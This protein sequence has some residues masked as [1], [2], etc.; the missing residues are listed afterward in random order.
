MAAKILLVLKQEGRKDARL[1]KLVRTFKKKGFQLENV[2]LKNLKFDQLE[3][4]LEKVKSNHK[5]VERI[6]LISNHRLLLW[7]WF[8]AYNSLIDDFIYVPAIEEKD[9]FHQ[10]PLKTLA[11]LYEMEKETIVGDI[12][13]DIDFENQHLLFPM[14]LV[15]FRFQYFSTMGEF[16]WDESPKKDPILKTYQLAGTTYSFGKIGMANETIELNDQ[17][18]K[19]FAMD[20][21]FMK[22]L[23]AKPD[24]CMYI[25]INVLN[26]QIPASM[27]GEV[28][29]T[30]FSL[31]QETTA[32]ESIFGDLEK[33]LMTSN[34]SFPERVYLLASSLF[35]K[36]KP[37]L[38]E[39]IHKTM[40][41]SPE[42]TSYHYPLLMSS[43]GFMTSYG[44]DK[45]EDL[46]NDQIQI[47][48]RI[49]TYYKSL[50]P[51]PVIQKKKKIILVVSQ[52][53]SVN[54]SPTSLAINYAIYLKKANP[55]YGISIFVDDFFA[56]SPNEVL[57]PNAYRSALSTQLQKEHE[58]MLDGHEVHLHYSDSSLPRVDRLKK[59]LIF[60]ENEGPELIW[61][62]GANFSLIGAILYDH[63]PVLSTTLGGAEPIPYAYLF[64]GGNTKEEM[65][66]EWKKH[67]G[68]SSKYKQI[69]YG[70]DLPGPTA[71][72]ERSK[73]GLTPDDFALATVGNRLDA[74]MTEEFISI[75]ND[76]LKKDHSIKWMIVGK[77]SF[78]DLR[79]ACKDFIQNKQIIFVDY[80]RDL[81]GFYQ[82]CDAY[83]N[84]FRQGGGISGAMAMNEG[85]PV[86][87][88]KGPYDVTIYT[89]NHA[90][91]E[92]EKFGAEIER[93]FLDPSYRKEKGEEMKQRIQEQ[94]GFDKAI[95]DIMECIEIAKKE[96]ENKNKQ[97]EA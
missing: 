47:M 70:L 66:D 46:F 79:D 22:A 65:E 8:R 25:C 83:V 77:G 31:F 91:V 94:F 49:V 6:S 52:L 15:N 43:L 14:L 57:F 42:Y 9:T 50:L 60:M 64:T 63:V 95:Q 17:K 4:V 59:D 7:G 1:Q 32:K 44:L 18:P 58:K 3:N 73:Y 41:Q 16:D 80:Q 61:K 30:I 71:V 21:D 39:L 92:K 53:L 29:N 72:E 12:Y 33:Y 93:L 24:L 78:G 5:K 86:V 23:A 2:S 55:E 82:L 37:K 85:L 54:H 19:P 10:E 40:L 88:L 96:F 75:M 35:L 90:A 87:T 76:V 13:V 11:N 28:L 36:H 67:N 45:Y 26:M 38:L 69:T 68:I 20:M 56:Y 48:E 84:P 81:P 27:K 74:E 51:E 34:P 62:L 89:G 97:S